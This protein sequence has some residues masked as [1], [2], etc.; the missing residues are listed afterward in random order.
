MKNTDKILIVDDEPDILRI[1]GGLL[2]GIGYSVLTA[3][4]GLQALDIFRN[5][6]ID[7][8]ITDV[9]MPGMDGI[10]LIRQ[11]NSMQ[12][13]LV[14]ILVITG[15][16]DITTAVDAMK[17]GAVNYLSK[18]INFAELEVALEQAIEKLNLMKNVQKKQ[19]QLQE[20][21]IEAEKANLAKSEFLANMSHEI[22]TP[23]NAILGM[24][25]LAIESASDPEQCKHLETV[26]LSAESLLRLLNGILDLSKIEANKFELNEMPFDLEGALKAIVR[27]YAVQAQEKGLELQYYLPARLHLVLLGDEYRLRQ[28]LLNLVDNAIKF[29]ET[30]RVDI[31]VEEISQNETGIVLQ[32]CVKDTGFGITVE[33]QDYI[34]DTFSQVDGSPTRKFGGAGLGLTICKKLTELL[35]GKI[36]VKSRPDQGSTFFFSVRYPKSDSN[37]VANRPSCVSGEAVSPHLDI[38]LVEDNQYN[39]EVIQVALKKLDHRIV[40][41][42]NGVEALEKLTSNYYDVILM[43]LQMPVLDGIET[44]NFIRMCEKESSIGSEFHQ[45]LLLRVQSNIKGRRLP[46][47]VITGDAMPGDRRKCFEFDIDD[48][49]TKPFRPE[50]LVQVI[51]QATEKRSLQKVVIESPPADQQEEKKYELEPAS[52]EL[53]RNHLIEAYEI[54]FEQADIMLK[55]GKESIL[56]EFKKTEEAISRNDIETLRRSVHSLKSVLGSMGLTSLADFSQKI[57]KHQT[58]ID[59]SLEE[60]L[61]ILRES[62]SQLL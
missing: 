15:H 39:R 20:A 24:N 30:G 32:F 19:K 45:E 50:E 35:G 36:W 52:I 62:L 55:S 41:V 48:Y 40:C 57:E 38:L 11:V 47:I 26:Q 25:R 17:L 5:E 54:S 6:A 44:T 31:E 12:A 28:I 2:Q 23:M 14:Q 60:Q 42:E 7:V 51:A 46:I 22:L 8:I 1:M 37:I 29:T 16:G 59:K 43:D 3:E 4:S 10:E 21:R 53:V 61:S 49:I 58:A 27:S 13:N 9:K 56:E 33:A 18:P 34:F